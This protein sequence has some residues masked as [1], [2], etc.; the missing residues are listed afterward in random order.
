MNDKNLHNEWLHRLNDGI[1][2]KDYMIYGEM[3]DEVEN[4]SDSVDYLRNI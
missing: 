4:D 2:Y 3:D 1:K